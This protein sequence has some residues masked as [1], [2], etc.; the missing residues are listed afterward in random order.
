MPRRALTL[1]VRSVVCN[2]GAADKGH[3][4][5]MGRKSRPGVTGCRTDSTE[6]AHPLATQKKI[7]ISNANLE[8]LRLIL[9]CRFR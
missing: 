3:R 4:L 1:S 2:R 5:A 9:L 8:F 6:G 7:A